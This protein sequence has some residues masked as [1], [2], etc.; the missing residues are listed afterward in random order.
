MDPLAFGVVSHAVAASEL[1]L[2]DEFLSAVSTRLGAPVRP[3]F[4]SSYDDIAAR[5]MAGALDVAWLPPIVFLGL[6]LRGVAVPLVTNPRG[7]EARFVSVLM[8]SASSAIRTA[9][10]LPGARVA[11]VERWSASGYVIPRMGLWAEGI[12]VRMAFGGERFF[13]SHEAVVR[14][15]LG[16]KADVGATYANT[17]ALGRI[18]RGAW[19]RLVGAEES[20]RIINTW[21]DIPSD[22]FAAHGNLSSR[23]RITVCNAML[24]AAASPR[25]RG[26]VRRIFGS[27]RLSP[28]SLETYEPLRARVM[29]AAALG[30]LDALK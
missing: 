3:Y 16:G 6:E 26:L 29:E 19:S 5:M 1:P 8:T 17:D 24:D 4:C 28:W 30:L 22:V 23:E 10:S 21:N 15:V 20:I 18:V 2:L 27:D 7:G 11:W 14:A 9:A 25:G 12:D 13:G